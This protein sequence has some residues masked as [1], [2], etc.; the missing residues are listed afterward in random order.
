MKFKL[1]EPLILMQITNQNYSQLHPINLSH[2]HLFETMHLCSLM[3]I[4]KSSPSGQWLKRVS[5]DLALWTRR[6]RK[7]RKALSTIPTRST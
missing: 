2:Q 4:L 7:K 3:L 5:L 1:Q 6:K